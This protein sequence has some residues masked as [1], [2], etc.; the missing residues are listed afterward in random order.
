MADRMMGLSMFSSSPLECRWEAHVKRFLD[1]VPL[2]RRKHA[3]VTI[4]SWTKS[5][6]GHN[7]GLLPTPGQQSAQADQRRRRA[8]YARHRKEILQNWAAYYEAHKDE[9]AERKRRKYYEDRNLPVPEVPTD[10]FRRPL[11]KTDA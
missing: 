1:E 10:R 6:L 3:V 5:F 7:D 9:I 11:K 4:W 2:D 8:R